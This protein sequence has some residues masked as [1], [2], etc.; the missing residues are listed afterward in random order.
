MLRLASDD[1]SINFK[2]HC[3]ELYGESGSTVECLDDQAMSSHSL[4][5]RPLAGEIGFSIGRIYTSLSG[6]TEERTTDGHGFMQLVLLGR[7]LRQRGYA[8][9]SLGHCYSPE[10]DYKRELGHRVY[11]RADFLALLKQHRGNFRQDVVPLEKGLLNDFQPL[12]DGET[13]NAKPLLE[14]RI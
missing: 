9:W 13:C 2:M 3:I 10:M 6:W 11:P 4:S 1:P 7:W 8:F 14:V 12:E 5:S